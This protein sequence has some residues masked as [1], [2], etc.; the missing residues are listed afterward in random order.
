MA[1]AF[2]PDLLLPPFVADALCLGPHWIYDGAEIRRHFGQDLS[3]FH[4]PL[5]KYHPGK[6]A[7]D[8]T[9]YGD[10]TLALLRSIAARGSFDPEG[11]R[12]DWSRFWSQNTASY[13]DGATRQTLENWTHGRFEPSASHD[14]GGASRIAPILAA[15]H[16]L[17]LDE[18]IAAARSQTALTHGDPAVHDAAE[19]FTRWVDAIASGAALPAALDTAASTT[20]AQGLDLT[21]LLQQAHRHAAS[22]PQDAAAAFGL[23]CNVLEALPLTL[24]LALQ[25]AD[26]PRQALVTNALLGG[27]SAARGLLLGLIMGAAHGTV[28]LPPVWLET[29]RARAE[30]HRLLGITPAP[31]ILIA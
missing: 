8:F 19:L 2:I 16:H 15:L 13:R 3:G 20:K 23:S 30:I 10:Q 24:C 7:G 11:W 27:D 12:E 17:P 22:S 6:Q 14:L 4:P 5:C 26:Q 31:D 18:R 28:W 21:S 9:H 29:L 1:A 25:Y